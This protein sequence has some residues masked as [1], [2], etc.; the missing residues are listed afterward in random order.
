MRAVLMAFASMLFAT[1]AAAQS[2]SPAQTAPHSDDLQAKLQ[3]ADA[4]FQKEDWAGA[5]KEYE[6]ILVAVPHNRF[7]HFR[8]GY[9]LHML[10]RLEEALPHHM[11]AA[12]INN[13]ALRIDALYNIAC[14]NALLGRKDQALRHL[15]HAIDTG[16]GDTD[17]IRKDTD[18]DSL[19]SDSEFQKLVASIG[20]EQTLP[21]Q[22]D[23][24]VGT[25]TARPENSTADQAPGRHVFARPT[26]SSHAMSSISTVGNIER[27]GLLTPNFADRS[28]RWVLADGMGTTRTLNGRFI[29]EATLRFEGRDSYA[30]GDGPPVRITISRESEKRI[31]IRAE[32]EEKSGA[33]TPAGEEAYERE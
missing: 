26:A 33:W 28:W 16:F 9:A 17:Q 31:R 5:V 10:K 30:T 8:V 12:Q 7:A 32:I 18:L 20:K 11:E 21:R 14:A 19:R 6:A 22:L 4:H 13:R 2:Q 1:A 24:L 3:S 23:F 25:W 15:R 27:A 29:D